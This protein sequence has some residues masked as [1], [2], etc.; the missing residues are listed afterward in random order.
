[1]TSSNNDRGLA[2]LLVIDGVVLA[3]A[4]WIISRLVDPPGAALIGFVLLAVNLA[5]AIAVVRG[6]GPQSRA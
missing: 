4:G 1:M 5:S 6:R 2:I 3:T